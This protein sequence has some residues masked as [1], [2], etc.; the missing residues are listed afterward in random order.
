MTVVGSGGVV[1]NSQSIQD[2]SI[3][4][5]DVSAS[6]GI[7]GSKLSPTIA[8]V[9]TKGDVLA[10]TAS[11]ALGRQAV[12][13][14]GAALVG[15]S[16]ETNGVGYSL[17]GDGMPAKY[18]AVT[19]ALAFNTNPIL[20]STARTLVDARQQLI[21][22]Y[23]PY[24][25]TITGLGWIQ[26]TTGDTTADNNNK[27]GLYTSDGTNLTLVASSADDGTLW[28]QGTGVQQ[29]AFSSTYAAEAGMYWA[30]ILA[31]WSAVATA[32]VILGSVGVDQAAQL[33]VKVTNANVKVNAYREGRTD[34]GGTIAWS[35]YVA[36]DEHFVFLY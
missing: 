4:N 34:L 1:V 12:G 3:V 17:L 14:N 35:D 33:T 24:K 28:E 5:A 19:S 7:V 18:R 36:S 11:G 22:I 29:K 27:V 2:G 31:N 15:S 8:A 9:T 26:K 23:L 16:G 20:S 32:P 10:A 25:A 21:G 6:A 13:A 30:S